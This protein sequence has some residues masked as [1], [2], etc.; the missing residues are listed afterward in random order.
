M[1][2]G[3]VQRRRMFEKEFG[4]AFFDMNQPHRHWE[5]RLG[6]L[7]VLYHLPLV[8]IVRVVAAILHV[9]HKFL[10]TGVV[11]ALTATTYTAVLV[12]LCD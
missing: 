1:F 7:F 9:R 6:T 3:A 11:M 5:N 12:W 10:L 8:I 2:V 4:P